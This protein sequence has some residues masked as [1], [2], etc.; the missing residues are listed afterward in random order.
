[1]K[2]L[3]PLLCIQLATINCEI[4]GA[5]E[6]SSN[7]FKTQLDG[8]FKKY[9]NDNIYKIKEYSRE[10]KF[11]NRRQ[12]TNNEGAPPDNNLVHDLSCGGNFIANLNTCLSQETE[13]NNFSCLQD[14]TVDQFSA[15]LSCD[16]SDVPNYGN[17]INAIVLNNLKNKDYINTLAKAKEAKKDNDRLSVGEIVI[18]VIEKLKIVANKNSLPYTT[19]HFIE[20][21]KEIQLE[22]Q[23]DE[24][25][26]STD[27]YNCLKL[28]DD[29]IYSVDTTSVCLCGYGYNKEIKGYNNDIKLNALYSYYGFSEQSFTDVCSPILENS[30]V[31]NNE[32]QFISEKVRD[33]SLSTLLKEYNIPNYGSV[34]NEMMMNTLKSQTLSLKKVVYNLYTEI[35]D[36][37]RNNYNENEASHEFGRCMVQAN[38]RVF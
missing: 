24:K 11:F 31:F 1:I 2:Y 18:D 5:N 22:E 27:Y 20:E 33:S 14:I 29:E 21:M 10:R 32:N 8:S 4:V 35:G 3:L 36:I 30:E 26:I 38:N 34:F 17:L 23:K 13:K 15:Y 9:F 28:V 37:S 7:H 25:L 6:Y 12:D 16:N 19:T